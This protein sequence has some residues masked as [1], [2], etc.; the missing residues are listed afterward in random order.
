ML[1]K[2]VSIARELVPASFEYIPHMEPQNAFEICGA[3]EQLLGIWL[4]QGTS[5]SS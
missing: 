4:L 2:T 3:F 1:A 5:Y